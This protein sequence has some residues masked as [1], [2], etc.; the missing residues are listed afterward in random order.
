MDL[1]LTSVTANRSLGRA[2]RR[3]SSALDELKS[4]VSCVGVQAWKYTT[5][6]LALVDES[7]AHVAVQRTPRGSRL[8]QIAVG[9]PQ[10]LT[11]APDD[12]PQL[13]SAIAGQLLR[14]LDHTGLSS[15]ARRE[16]T[17]RIGS[18]RDRIYAQ[19]GRRPVQ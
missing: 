15:E 14:S 11:F 8:L 2:L 3:V 4:S 6:Q 13:L 18:W 17:Q 10:G 1:S 12:D 16:L 5:L 19:L 9:L 7:E